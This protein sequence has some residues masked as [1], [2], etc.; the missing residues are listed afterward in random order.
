MSDD[1]I[2][3]NSTNSKAAATIVNDRLSRAPRAH[4]NAHIFEIFLTTI[5]ANAKTHGKTGSEFPAAE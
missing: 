1:R 5:P 3:V 4:T 2:M